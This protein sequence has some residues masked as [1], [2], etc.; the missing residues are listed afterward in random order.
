MHGV[1]MLAAL[2]RSSSQH[3]AHLRRDRSIAR[4]RWMAT[5]LAPYSSALVG[6]SCLGVGAGGPAAGVRRPC[7]G[8]A[9]HGTGGPGARLRRPPDVTGR[10]KGCGSCRLRPAGPLRCW[11]S[12][13]RVPPRGL[14]GGTRKRPGRSM[15]GRGRWSGA[16]GGDNAASAERAGGLRSPAMH[17][18]SQGHAGHTGRPERVGIDRYLDRCL[19]AGRRLGCSTLHARLFW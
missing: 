12:C 4:S 9:W 7:H 13:A 1:G 8:V 3:A 19:L 17:G 16:H 11:S 18:V 6:C 10:V 14:I 15:P 5:E 2:S